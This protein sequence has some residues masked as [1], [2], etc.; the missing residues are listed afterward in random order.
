MH[1]AHAAL[2]AFCRVID[3]I[4]EPRPR[5]GDGHAV[6]IDLV[7]HGEF[8]ACKLPHRALA[9]R[10][11]MKAHRLARVFLEFV[12]VGFETLPEHVIVV[13]ARERGSGQRLFFRVGD[14]VSRLQRPDTCHGFAKQIGVVVA[15]NESSGWLWLGAVFQYSEPVPG[16]QSKSLV[17]KNENPRK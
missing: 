3:E 11:T 4:G 10:R 5:L 14:A 6:Q 2:A 16:R 17:P 12:D 8:A 9:D 7:L 15:H 13:G 1:D